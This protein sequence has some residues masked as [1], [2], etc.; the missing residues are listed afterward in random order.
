MRLIA[1]RQEGKPVKDKYKYSAYLIVLYIDNMYV[2]V[3]LIGLLIVLRT[4]R[5]TVWDQPWVEASREKRD[6]GQGSPSVS[7]ADPKTGCK[8]FSCGLS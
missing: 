4:A 7:L 1:L 6:I 8:C 2:I 5:G 3:L